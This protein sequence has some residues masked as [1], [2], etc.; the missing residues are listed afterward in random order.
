MRI[1]SRISVIP[2]LAA[3]AIHFGCGDPPLVSASDP[4]DQDEPPNAPKVPE[5]PRK[6]VDRENPIEPE[7]PQTEPEKPVR[8]RRRLR[9]GILPD[10]QGGR[11]AIASH[12]MRAILEKFEAEGVDIVI[13]VGD[14]TDNGTTGEF[15]QWTSIAA[16]FRDRGIEFLPLMGNHEDSWAWTV[17]WIDFMKDFI[18]RD[19]YHLVGAEY[20]D[21]YVIRENVLFILLKYYHLPIAFPWIE[22]VV[23]ENRDKVDHIV[24]ASHDGL[25]G[26]KYGETRE[27]IVEGV[28]GDDLLHDSWDE[29]RGFLSKHDVIWVQGHEHLY[30]R[31]VIR[32][33][34]GYGHES[35]TPADGPHRMQMYTQIM[36]GNASYKGYE[37]RYGERELVQNIIQMKMATMSNGST[38][39]DANATI[40]TFDDERVDLEAYYVE[41][42]VTSDADGPKELA[43]PEWKLFD[44]FSRTTR[45][46][47][48]I[49]FSNSIPD[50]TR[51]VLQFHPYYWTNECVA[52]DGSVAAILDGENAT[53]NRVEST[54]RTLSWTPGFSRAQSQ[55][56]LMRLAYQFLFQYHQDWSPNL[57][58]NN[59]I[60]PGANEFQVLVPETTIDLEEH[61]TLS[62]LPK[63]EETLSDIVIVSGTQ[64]QTG[65]YISAYG[66]EKDIEVDLGLPGSQPD[67]TAKGPVV[68]PEGATKKWDISDAVS[69]AYALEFVPPPGIS[70]AESTL[71]HKVAEGWKSLASDECIVQGPYDSE[72]LDAPPSRPT[73]CRGEPLVGFDEDRGAW[74]LVV[75]SD[76]ELALVSR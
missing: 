40:L 7:D 32:G 24:I 51:P 29:I 43:H 27:M 3:L 61:V 26:A 10:T 76:V 2:M 65:T 42:T 50:S 52:E 8:P 53:F 23:N 34:L 54:T 9:V 62:W 35:W 57:N 11:D 37:F 30:Q 16:E 36:A 59:R 73:V 46:C 45:R 18:P 31:S 48:R 4:R 12:P 41:H 58:G 64:Q 70:R 75:R 49:V 72:Y 47:E 15:L 6:P 1:R 20:L 19:A 67:G 55:A 66:A 69:D 56:E 14:L 60:L 68:L 22:K 25:I 39:F 63:A 74:W 13:P 21:Y 5:N 44:K 71:A 28:M 38:S 33:P 17:E